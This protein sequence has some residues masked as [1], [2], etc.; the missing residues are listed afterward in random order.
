MLPL[1]LAAFYETARQGSVTAAARRL[2]MSQPTI[3][4]RIQQLERHYGVE[5]FHRRGNRLDLSDAGAAL[6]P[7]VGQMM[8]IENDIDFALR[9]ERE[10]RTGNLRVGTTGPF[11]ILPAIAAFRRQYPAVK[12]SIE[13]GNSQQV[14]DALVDFRVDIAVSSQRDDDPRFV[15][16]TIANDPLVVVV[17][18]SHP[19]ATREAIPLAALAGE[20]L[21]LREPGSRTRS[22][23]E[24]VLRL[25]GIELPASVIELGSREAVR[26]AVRHDMGCTLMPR[27][28]VGSDP[29]LCAIPLVDEMP[30]MHEYLYYLDAR[31]GTRLISAFM[32]NV[33]PRA[34]SRTDEGEPAPA[35]R[36]SRARPLPDR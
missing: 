4:S 33:E 25:A 5:L 28:E 34:G 30:P 7:L 3:T 19:F 1:L 22:M 12:I 20:A 16:H 11:Y 8:Q 17:H 29:E 14:L 10:L 13:I 31:G 21:L 6:M 24:D 27:G 35:A 32:A 15:R 26:E 23:M 18:P 36:L 9:N 2:D